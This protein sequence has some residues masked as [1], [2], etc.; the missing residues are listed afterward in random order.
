MKIASMGRFIYFWSSSII[1]VVSSY[2]IPVVVMSM[3]PFCIACV[4][5]SEYKF[6]VRVRNIVSEIS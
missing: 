3:S 5:I 1:V 6:Q 2:V 4:I